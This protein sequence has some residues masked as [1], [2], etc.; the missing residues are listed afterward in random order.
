MVYAAMPCPDILYL[1]R[2]V[3]TDVGYAATSWSGGGQQQQQV[4]SVLCLVLSAVSSYA[5]RVLSVLSLVLSA[6]SS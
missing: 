2:H 1:L 4:P 3:G 5:M 6:V